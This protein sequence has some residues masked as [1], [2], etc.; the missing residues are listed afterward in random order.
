MNLL[1]FGL[2]GFQSIMTRNKTLNLSQPTDAISVLSW[3]VCVRVHMRVYA[4]TF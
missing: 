1:N 4:Y 2:H 3:C